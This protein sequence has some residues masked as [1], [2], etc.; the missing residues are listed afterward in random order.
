MMNFNR[1]ATEE[2]WAI[3]FI[4]ELQ[5]GYRED[6]RR[7]LDVS[8]DIEQA[9]KS[10]TK[11]ILRE[12]FQKEAWA[13]LISRN[14]KC[15][16]RTG[17]SLINDSAQK[18]QHGRRIETWFIFLAKGMTTYYQREQ[19]RKST[20]LNFLLVSF[21]IIKDK[22]QGIRDIADWQSALE[23]VSLIVWMMVKCI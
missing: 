13:A 4:K 2:E 11:V 10:K 9:K 1:L 22:Q 12:R 21:D 19:I 7:E 20:T 3:V 17:C 14:L 23:P 18:R 8:L 15:R 6:A 5:S 16:T